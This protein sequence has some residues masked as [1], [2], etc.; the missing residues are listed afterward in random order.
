MKKLVSLFL[1]MVMTFCAV[2]AFAAT[3]IN[4]DA[5]QEQGAD[6]IANGKMVTF[7]EISVQMWMPNVLIPAELTDEDKAQG[8][9]GYYATESGSAAVAVM[10]ADVNGMTL[11][12]YKAQLAEIGATEIEDV[13]INGLPAVSYALEETD[14]A[15]VAFATEA[16]YIF[17]V[18]GAP[19]SDGGF[20]SVLMFVMASIQAA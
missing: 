8:Y 15:C 9:I 3:E 10:Y 12:D 1:A 13:I 18:S 17:E 16:G 6:M 7:D 2:S 14:T 19:K 20:A 4:W 11:E 5:L